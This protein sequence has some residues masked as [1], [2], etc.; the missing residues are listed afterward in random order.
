MV[1]MESTRNS[2]N[3]QVMDQQLKS[4]TSESRVR[5]KGDFNGWLTPANKFIDYT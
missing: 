3:E 5:K 2:I 1:E 4:P